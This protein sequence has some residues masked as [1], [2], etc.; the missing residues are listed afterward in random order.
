MT[1][2][3]QQGTPAD[4][5]LRVAVEA[6]A[7]ALAAI[8][9]PIVRATAI[10]FELE[11]PDADEF[12]QRLRACRQLAPWILAERD[13]VV[14]AY[15]YGTRYRARPA[16][17]W[18]VE[19]SIYVAAEARRAGVA[20]RLYSALLDALAL[21]GFRTAVGGITLPNAPSVALHEQL[22]FSPAGVVPRAGWKLGAWHGV[23]FWTRELGVA[24]DPPAPVRSVAELEA[25]TRFEAL[26]RGPEG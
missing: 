9:A 26:L 12:V 6:D 3:A 2:R 15:A 7:P 17:D 5:R 11:V 14:C 21:Q 13:G 4:M 18:I 16:Y 20:R 19:T 24:E 1:S 8:Y 10:S 22:G 23:G 25:D